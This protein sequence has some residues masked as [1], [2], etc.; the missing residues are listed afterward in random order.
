MRQLNSNWKEEEADTAYRETSTPLGELSVQIKCAMDTFEQ[1]II[2]A[3]TRMKAFGRA[4]KLLKEKAPRG[5][6]KKKIGW[7]Q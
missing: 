2:R 3:I 5:T 7:M 1:N 4:V 6:R